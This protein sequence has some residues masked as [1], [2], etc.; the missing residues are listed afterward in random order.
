MLRVNARERGKIKEDS[1]RF[2]GSSNY[3]RKEKR[4][5]DAVRGEIGYFERR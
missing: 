3:Q 5:E 2:D 1:A 4:K